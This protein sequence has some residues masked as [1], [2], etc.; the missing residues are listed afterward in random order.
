M[1]LKKSE[2]KELIREC[3]RKELNSSSLK[4]AAFSGGVA[5]SGSLD[6]YKRAGGQKK[7]WKDALEGKKT[8][9]VKAKDLKPGMITSTG[10]VRSVKDLGWVWGQPTLEIGYGGIGAQGS[11]A[12]DRVSPDKDYEVLDESCATEKVQEDVVTPSYTWD[13]L[14]AEAD[15][16]LAELTKAANEEQYD[17]ADGYWQVEYSEWCNRYLYYKEKFADSA[18]LDRLCKIFSRL[19]PNVEFYYFEDDQGDASEIGYVAVKHGLN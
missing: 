17:D 19:L 11:Y 8:K 2:L 10:E 12:S 7:V 9:T 14:V 4:E 13:R 15:K 16:Y 5:S 18:R 3:V 6:T 1:K